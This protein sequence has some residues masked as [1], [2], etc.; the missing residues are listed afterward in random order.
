VAA[1]A[2]WLE[3][4]LPQRWA[5][6]PSSLGAV[7]FVVTLAASAVATLLTPYHVQLYRAVVDHVT[8][9]G[10]FDLVSELQALG[11]RGLSDWLVLSLL[12]GAVIAVARAPRVPPFFVLLLTAAT[13][14][15][16]RAARDVW[17]LVIVSA[18]TIASV[19]RVDAV[20]RYR[21]STRITVVSIAVAACVLGGLVFARGMPPRSFASA[22]TETF[23]VNAIKVV[24]ERGYAGPLF[25]HYDWGGYLIWALP[26]L[27]VSMDGRANL[28]GPEK[29][30][31]SA[32]TWSGV[33]GWATDPDLARARL[34]IAARQLALSEL[35]R[36]DAR[37]EV[38]WEDPLTVVFV[39]RQ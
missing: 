38:A 12:L 36:R 9:T 15:S 5:G 11:F 23:P 22:V 27:P 24:E 32:E 7:P 1:V 21:A 31:K 39:A 20:G 29:I 37:F 19:L 34:V 8:Q 25:N 13:F 3:R 17:F 6:N 18:V 26:R 4:H 16:F 33:P 14:V 30:R 28:Y 2:P 10:T 35:L